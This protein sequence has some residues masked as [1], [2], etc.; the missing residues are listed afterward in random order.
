MS[1]KP[2]WSVELDYFEAYDNLERDCQY[3]N[4]LYDALMTGANSIKLNGQYIGYVTE[5]GDFDIEEKAFANMTDT[6]L[7]NVRVEFECLDKDADGYTIAKFHID[8]LL[9]KSK[10]N[11]NAYE[12]VQRWLESIVCE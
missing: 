9:D 12:Y 8:T 7:G 11:L 6:Q 10:W 3:A 2:F 1:S 5:R 4:N